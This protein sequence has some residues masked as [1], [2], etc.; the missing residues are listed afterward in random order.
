MENVRVS[1]KYSF[2]DMKTWRKL[3][4]RESSC[5]CR[6]SFILCT[7]GGRSSAQNETLL[8]LIAALRC[9]IYLVKLK[10][11]KTLFR[12]VLFEIILASPQLEHSVV[13][14][15]VDRWRHAMGRGSNCRHGIANNRKCRPKSSCSQLVVLMKSRHQPSSEF[16]FCYGTIRHEMLF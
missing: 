14:T 9:N 5:Q 7:R 6:Q 2:R 15:E 4:V 16:F 3:K 11:R 12:H 8:G 10:W 1:S 13:Q